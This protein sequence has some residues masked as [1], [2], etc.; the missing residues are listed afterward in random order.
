MV[1]FPIDSG[2]SVNSLLNDKSNIVHETAD[3]IYHILVALEA[4]DV[5]F[6]DVLKELENRQKH[7]G[8][9]EKNNR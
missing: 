4:A 8:I 3:T 6:E 2:N 5:R 9:E 7:S 1:K